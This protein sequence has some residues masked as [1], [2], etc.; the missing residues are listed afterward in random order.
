MQQDE[1]P[2]ASPDLPIACS[3]TQNELAN[4]KNDIQGITTSFQAIR[5]LSDGYALQYPSEKIWIENLVQFISQERACCPFFTF[6]LVFEPAQGPLWLRIYGPEGTK[7]M[8]KDLLP[9]FL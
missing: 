2:V 1:H 5:E 7:S 8:I 9:S 6:E 4:R 3:L